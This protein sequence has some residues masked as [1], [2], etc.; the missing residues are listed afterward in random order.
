M[1]IKQLRDLRVP[2]DESATGDSIQLKKIR[3]MLNHGLKD[4]PQ[5]PF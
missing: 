3:Q 5:K 1:R 4:E 2:G